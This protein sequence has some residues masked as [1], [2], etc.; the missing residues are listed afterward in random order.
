MKALVLLLLLLVFIGCAVLGFQAA[1]K[2]NPTPTAAKGVGPVDGV[3]GEQHNLLIVRVDRFDAAQPRLIS[4]WF[5]SLFFLQDTPTILTL[6]QI[7]P[8]SSSQAGSLAE[9]FAFSAQGD[10][11]RAFWEALSVYG[12]HWES[13][14]VLDTEGANLFLQWLVG[15]GDFT[16]ALEAAS[17]SRDNSR[18]MV[19]QTCQS[20]ADASNRELGEFNWSA[21]AP[22]HFRSDMRLEAGL[23]YWDRLVDTGPAR[24][25]ILPA[26]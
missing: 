1:N 2:L 22:A 6:A 17:T 24:C 16:A 3:Q 23:A 18:R 26:Q 9:S 5:V 7:Y 15:P 19:E 25:E 14:V 8:D 13:Y 11:D 4:I 21:L 20:I 12:F 10:P